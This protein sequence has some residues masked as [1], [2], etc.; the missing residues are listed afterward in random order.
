MDRTL[1]WASTSTEIVKKFK[2]NYIQAIQF[3]QRLPFCNWQKNERTQAFEN[4][5]S[6][7]ISKFPEFQSPVSEWLTVQLNVKTDQAAE[8]EYS[9]NLH[10]VQISVALG[11]MMR[12]N[13][14]WIRTAFSKSRPKTS[15]IFCT[16][17]QLQHS[18]IKC[19][20]NKPH[21]LTN[22]I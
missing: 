12:H 18:I 17:L 8:F 22:D 7:R 16:L 13:T 14:R 15:C 1:R 6:F 3:I 19:N 5:C 11:F 4:S 20:E 21:E 10:L 9:E 2:Q